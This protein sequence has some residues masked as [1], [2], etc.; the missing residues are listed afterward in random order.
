[1]LPVV[2]CA[3]MG[4]AAGACG[5]HSPSEASASGSKVSGKGRKHLRRLCVL[6]PSM[7]SLQFHRTGRTIIQTL[8]RPL[9]GSSEFFPKA[10]KNLTCFSLSSC[11]TNPKSPQLLNT[12]QRVYKKN[13][14]NQVPCF[15]GLLGLKTSPSSSHWFSFP[16]PP[17]PSHKDKRK[18]KRDKKPLPFS[19][20]VSSA[21]SQQQS[22]P[23][24][25]GGRGWGGEAVTHRTC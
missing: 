9:K 4:E 15:E 12:A 2:C 3:V 24:A 6:A 8:C 7:E 21:Y 22:M 11:P 1:M 17:C 18:R 25:E 16:C 20:S 14:K 13:V 10:S 23:H 19:S 5:H